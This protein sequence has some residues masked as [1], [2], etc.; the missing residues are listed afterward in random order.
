VNEESR[1]QG[2]AHQTPAKVSKPS[3]PPAGE[4]AQTLA[5]LE[6]V[7]TKGT[8]SRALCPAH[9][10]NK[11]S[12][13]VAPGDKHE[14]V[15]KCHAGCTYAEVRAALDDLATATGVPIRRPRT[16]TAA[17]GELVAEYD[18]T[19]EH[20]ALL[21]QVVRY[22]PKDFRQRQP[23]GNG[24]TWSVSNP[25][26]SVVPYRLPEL[27]AAKASGATVYV[28]EGEADADAL[29]ELGHVATCNHGGASKWRAA[30]TEA[31]AGLAKVVIVADRDKAGEKHA[32]E[33]AAALFGE[34]GV[35]EVVQAVT[36]KDARDHL[37]AGYTV[38]EFVPMD[39]E[40][41]HRG[42]LRMAQRLIAGH[43]GRLR[44]VHDVG[45]HIWDG[46][47]WALDRDGEATRAAIATVR[48]AYGD[49]PKLP[50]KA[51]KGLLADIHKCESAGGVDG[52]LRL[53]GCLYPVAVAVSKLDADPFLFNV[54]NGTLDLTTG[55]LRKHDPADL[56][57]KVAGCDYDPHATSPTF[58][59]F[60]ADVLPD[61]D[62]RAFVARI[63]GHALVGRVIEHVLPILTGVGMNGK[64]TLVDTVAAAFGDY[65]IAAEPDLLVERGSVHTTGQADLLGV[66]LAVC[67]ETDEGRRLAAATV[68]RLTGG[69]TLRARRMRENNIEFPASHSVFM[70]TNH[71]PKVA[72]DDP[73]LWRRLRIIPFDVVV[74]HPDRRLKEK[75]A[76]DLS[77]VLAWMGA[78][79]ADWS[80]NG[81]AEPAQVVAATKDYQTSSDDL[82]RFLDERCTTGNREE[83][84]AR[85]LFDAWQ[86]WCDESNEKP[87][88]EVVFAQAM[89][90]RGFAKRTLEGRRKYVGLA[91]MPREKM[92]LRPA[93][94]P[95]SGEGRG[96]SDPS[97]YTGS[98]SPMDGETL[99]D[100]HL[101]PSVTVALPADGKGESPLPAGTPDKS[102]AA[103]VGARCTLTAEP[104]TPLW[105][106]SC[107]YNKWADLPASAAPGTVLA[108]VLA[109]G[110]VFS[111]ASNPT[112]PISHRLNIAVKKQ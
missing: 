34:V 61:A 50:P 76:A 81:L 58:D 2:A 39:D 52:M 43:G 20:G 7:S 14:V 13:S 6:V 63:F 32:R 100:P 18:Y 24:W 73:A 89:G 11:A 17:L 23:N 40:E 21:F 59:R 71:K 44:H 86:T 84:A 75:L 15:L 72:G 57:T 104:T 106:F 105:G 33:V 46:K 103:F 96:G 45:W 95:K 62:V 93:E 54:G 74:A 38:A 64:T 12:L 88:T 5:L 66:R 16:A 97:S 77:A 90:R 22:E 26:V 25:P 87:G 107:A 42:Q 37:A 53:A 79:H 41:V 51:Q 70:V 29:A 91:L 68:K 82:G 101:S 94:T 85:E 80:A 30:H 36:G 112:D 10:D 56:M 19:D 78:G 27:V 3:V 110:G 69:D 9:D 111:I 1:P 4:L 99:T 83:V 102:M 35:V 31:L 8:E 48:A 109:I 108:A 49:L 98:V 67:A 60:L 65:A 28:T 47:R 92:W 55:E